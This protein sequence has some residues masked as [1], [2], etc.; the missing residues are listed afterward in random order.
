[1]GSAGILRRKVAGPPSRSI[2][3][4]VC[5]DANID[6]NALDISTRNLV[7]VGL[8]ARYLRRTCTSAS[9]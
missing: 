9:A 4:S 8:V 7:Q 6:L 2:R 1:M 3:F 5:A